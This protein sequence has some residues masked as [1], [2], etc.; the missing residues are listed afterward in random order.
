MPA[1]QSWLADGPVTSHTHAVRN[2]A[3]EGSGEPELQ[4]WLGQQQAGPTWLR[5]HR[6][7]QV[8]AGGC[9]VKLWGGSRGCIDDSAAAAAA[10]STSVKYTGCLEL[11]IHL[12]SLHA[13]SAS[14]HCATSMQRVVRTLTVRSVC[15]RCVPHCVSRAM[16]PLLLQLLSRTTTMSSNWQPAAAG[17]TVSCTSTAGRC[18]RCCTCNR[19]LR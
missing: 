10:T 6:C 13:R 12:A 16:K 2:C 18:R 17:R 3:G 11:A 1:T 7:R 4:C 9:G 8:P 14:V 5:Q 15:V 19:L